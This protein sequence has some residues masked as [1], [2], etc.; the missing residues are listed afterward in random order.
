MLLTETS[1][2]KRPRLKLRHY[3]GT[4]IGFCMLGSCALWIG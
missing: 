1:L 3:V 4:R 2:L